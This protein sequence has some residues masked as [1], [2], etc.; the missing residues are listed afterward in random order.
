MNQVDVLSFL[1]QG[2]AYGI[3]IGFIFSLF[4]LVRK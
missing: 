4:R 2:I 1:I 3:V